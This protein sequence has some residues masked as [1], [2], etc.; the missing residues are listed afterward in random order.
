MPHAQASGFPS[1]CIWP[2]DRLTPVVQDRLILIRSGAG[3]PEL[4]RWAQCLLGVARS[5]RGDNYGN[6]FMKHPDFIKARCL[7]AA[8]VCC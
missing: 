7:S 2:A 8:R 4:Q 1:P 3:A 6:G 5:P